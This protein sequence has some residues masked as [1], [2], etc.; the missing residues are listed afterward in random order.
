MPAPAGEAHAPLP[1]QELLL[2]RQ[3]L[4][5]VVAGRPREQLE[6]AAL[7]AAA[8]QK[9]GPDVIINSGA[10]LPALVDAGA[11]Y[12]INSYWN[13]FSGAKYFSPSTI[14]RVNGQVYGAQ[15]YVNLIALWYNEDILKKVGIK[16]PTTIT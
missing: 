5:E 8:G 10:N 14:S 11:L 3:P 13:A 7:V 1:G 12:N 4:L 2:G 9:I 6:A 15:A 16:P